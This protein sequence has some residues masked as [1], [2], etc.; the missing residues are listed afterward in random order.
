MNA[1]VIDMKGIMA[2]L[3]NKFFANKFTQIILATIQ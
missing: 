2:L 1:L 3:K